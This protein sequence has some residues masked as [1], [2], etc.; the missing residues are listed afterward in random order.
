[1]AETR[2]GLPPPLS[3]RRAARLPAAPTGAR[4][5][6][7]PAT[8][9]PVD[10]PGEFQAGV[11]RGAGSTAATLA[12][13]VGAGARA[14]GAPGLAE[15]PEAFAEQAE[16]ALVAP[17]PGRITRLEDIRTDD[18]AS[19]VQDV[20]DYVAGLFGSQVP[21]I[22]TIAAGGAV[23]GAA[24]GLAGGV[25]G[26]AG[27]SM[28]QQA[29]EAAGAIA[30]DQER[31]LTQGE[32]GVALGA[33]ALGGTLEVL[34]VVRA[35]RVLGLGG[36][37]RSAVRRG[38]LSRAGREAATQAALEGST[39][40]LQQVIQRSARAFVSDNFDVLGPGA[41]SELLNAAAAGAIVGGGIGGL[42]GAL[43]RPEVRDPDEDALLEQDL[44]DLEA[45]EQLRSA[46]RDRLVSQLRET[47]TVSDHFL[48][49]VSRES[50]VDEDTLEELRSHLPP[51]VREQSDLGFQGMAQEEPEEVVEL[52]LDRLRDGQELSRREAQAAAGALQAMDSEQVIA[53]ANRQDNQN[54]RTADLLSRFARVSEGARAE[55]EAQVEAGAGA[56]GSSVDDLES[57]AV[58]SALDGYFSIKTRLPRQGQW[59][60]DHHTGGFFRDSEHVRKSQESLEARDGNLRY[61]RV[62]AREIVEGELRDRGR[63]GDLRAEQAAALNELEARVGDPKDKKM[64]REVLDRVRAA[65]RAWLREGAMP[66]GPRLERAVRKLVDDPLSVFDN[67]FALVPTSAPGAFVGEDPLSL[68]R[69][70]LQPPLTREQRQQRSQELG[71]ARGPEQA[72]AVKNKFRQL[73]ARKAIVRASTERKRTPNAREAIAENPEGKQVFIHLPNLVRQ[74]VR[75][76][77]RLSGREFN[78]FTTPQ[79]VVDGL[80]LGLSSLEAEGLRLQQVPDDTVVWS[81]RRRDGVP[82]PFTWGELRSVGT[83]RLQLRAQALERRLEDAPHQLNELE[84][85]LKERGLAAD[86]KAYLQGQQKELK[87]LLK[88]GP[89]LLKREQAFA[90]RFAAGSEALLQGGELSLEGSQAVS[91]AM[92]ALGERGELAALGQEGS[93]EGDADFLDPVDER[94]AQGE[95]ADQLL[96]PFAGITEVG[97]LENLAEAEANPQLPGHIAR[98][99]ITGNRASPG[100]DGPRSGADPR[101]EADLESM[102]IGEERLGQHVGEAIA[103]ALPGGQVREQRTV[104]S[105][106][107][108][109]IRGEL[110]EAP[111]HQQ[112]KRTVKRWA[113]ELGLPEDT[114]LMSTS[115]VLQ[116]LREHG[117]IGRLHRIRQGTLT[118]LSIDNAVWVHPALEK[119]ARLETMAHE[120]GHVIAGATAPH[121][122]DAVYE[123]WVNWRKQQTRP[124]TTLQDVAM[125]K[126][127]FFTA[128]RNFGRLDNPALSSLNQVERAYV[129]DFEEWFSDQVARHLAGDPSPDLEVRGW[130]ERFIQAIKK[131]FG[132]VR[133]QG[134]KA[135]PTVSHFLT[136][137]TL[138]DELVGARVREA[139]QVGGQNYTPNQFYA[140]LAATTPGSQTAYPGLLLLLQEQSE[141]VQRALGNAF[142]SDGTLRHQVMQLMRQANHRM[143]AHRVRVDPDAAV[144]YGM[145]LW[146]HGLLQVGPRTQGHLERWRDQIFELAGQVSEQQ[147][148][149]EALQ[150]V[151]QGQGSS[152]V[153][154]R[155]RR[156]TSMQRSA[157][158]AADLWRSWL[159]PLV[160]RIALPAYQ[161]LEDS[162]NPHLRELA[163]MF[164]NPPGQA[165][166][167]EAY[168]A[169]KSRH[170]SARL[171][172][173]HRAFGDKPPADLIKEVH[174]A[175]QRGQQAPSARGQ[176]AQAKVRQLLDEMFRY[177]ARQGELPSH[178]FR[179]NYYP[180]V[181]DVEALQEQGAEWRRRA[182]NPAHNEAW[183]AIQLN[184]QK[185]LD[186]YRRLEQDARRS[187]QPIPFPDRFQQRAL[188]IEAR[189]NSISLEGVVDTTYRSLVNEYGFNSLD[190]EFDAVGNNPFVAAR[191]KRALDFLYKGPEAD[192]FFGLLSQDLDYTLRAYIESAVKRTELDRLGGIQRV[193]R[194]I[195]RAHE[196]GASEQEMKLASQWV[197]AAQGTLGHETAQWVATLVGMDAPEPGTV[198][199]PRLQKAQAVILLW[200]NLRVLALAGFTSL[201]DPVGI[202]V[203]GGGMDAV[204]G[205]IR[206]MQGT[207]Y[208]RKV[209]EGLG[210][211]STYSINEALG[212]IYGSNYMV[213]KT[214][215][216]NERFFKLIGLEWI[217]RTTRTMATGTALQFL[218][219]HSQR[220]DA[221]SE[222]FLQE[223]G[224]D[225]G[226]I[227]L[228]TEGNV[229]LRTR[230]E[231]DRLYDDGD[232]PEVHR[233]TRVRAAINKFVDEAVLRPTAATRPIW[234]SDPH[235]ALLFH[236]KSFIYTF[237]AQ[238]LTRVWREG[239]KHDQL[240]PLLLLSIYVPAM[241]GADLLRDFARFGPGGDPSKENWTPV[242]WAMHATERAGLPGLASFVLDAQQDRQWGGIG[243]E[244]ALGPTADSAT[245]LLGDLF[246]GELGAESLLEQLPGQN[247]IRP[248]L[249]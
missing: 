54:P 19:M 42:T 48:D 33:G 176:D 151:M 153:V 162:G 46:E 114:K 91:E 30:E 157:Q 53:L 76:Q 133:E 144:V 217:T 240:T 70:Q 96:N 206:A 136:R 159:G 241:I 28:L 8:P 110:G 224:L 20:S 16:S 44:E 228:N 189:Y 220:P 26:A 87:S 185:S 186:T 1:M 36:P 167:R 148:A 86:R 202:L 179:R 236:L 63:L 49:Q 158:A 201:A 37:M 130:M 203:R 175:M 233:D 234:A 196:S 204:H 198:I 178:A 194:L 77:R 119:G 154:S 34:P 75:A 5:P 210:I 118:G 227:Q 13:G 43:S 59:V 156:V 39:E 99:D 215:A 181:H 183:A 82:E 209:A 80:M 169:A 171:D 112:D 192:F 238:I 67:R 56:L 27:T 134:F 14:V 66:E 166:V 129:L 242:D 146:A 208:E 165:T 182:L 81:E 104:D 152:Y 17:N 164:H 184:Y 111:T 88:R 4:L 193:R 244:S 84:L 142:A 212:G 239:V 71:A 9:E 62:P 205:S 145:Q 41:A 199:D 219:H 177:L 191:N 47:E 18:T 95:Q 6:P 24:A 11:R 222:R 223:L 116:I 173:L 231:L 64:T 207:S 52:A 214:Q 190:L 109:G 35:G 237:H 58:G 83:A 174:L 55:R 94:V 92:E 93:F 105:A 247:V 3:R 78:A 132:L 2:F 197:E 68:T 170:T 85:R 51:E 140:L 218:L 125:S 23:G 12:R 69:E 138:R 226:D 121:N 249:E 40:A 31:P 143:A 15:A 38:L 10:R 120:L 101:V 235:F 147:Q 248:R 211:I 188:D 97:E 150:A 126:Q 172:Q 127:A 229:L 7:A 124:G 25:A 221:N 160:E 187:G 246:T 103:A 168:L 79:E 90:R 89:N 32:A 45:E 128:M 106:E 232:L 29:G 65:A 225:P 213:G 72:K 155:V 200:Q 122:S 230:A 123:A 149:Q 137:M 60:G 74:M 115:E 161:R 113:K 245:E 107:F 108:E 180:R 195:A 21:V 141:S 50:F 135:D 102:L 243:I 57:D 73:R 216:W 61:E 22:G 98:P 100:L 117:D 163:R 131:L 139:A